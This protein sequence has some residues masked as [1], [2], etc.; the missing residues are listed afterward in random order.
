MVLKVFEP[1]MFCRGDAGERPS[2]PYYFRW[3]NAVPPDKNQAWGNAVP[4]TRIKPRGT[5]FITA[6][7]FLL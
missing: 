1:V 6:V 5:P 4:L 7:L 3:G 2:G